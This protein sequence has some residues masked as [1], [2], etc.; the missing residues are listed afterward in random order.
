MTDQPLSFSERRRKLLEERG[1]LPAEPATPTQP[2][3]S[4][5][6]ATGAAW[7]QDLIPDISDD[8]SETDIAI[9]RT[10]ENISILE[11]YQKWIGKEIDWSTRGRADG[12]MVSCPMP[13]HRDSNPSA[14]INE[15]KGVW[16]CGVCVRGGDKFDLAAI[17][18]HFD[19]DDYK[20]GSNFHKV[21]EA[22]AAD[23]GTNIHR[24]AN[25]VEVVWYDE[26]SP[27]AAIA[28]QP[29]AP[30]P[31][32]SSVGAESTG[33]QDAVP[34]STPSAPV[35]PSAP[36]TPSTPPVAAVDTGV[37][38]RVGDADVQP[39]QRVDESSSPV[40]AP[41]VPITKNEVEEETAEVINYPTLDWRSIVPEGT[42]LYEYIKACSVDDSPEEF[43]FWNG[44]MMISLAASRRVYLD[45]LRKTI[46][47]LA[48]VV[49]GPTAVGKT[50]SRRHMQQ[51]LRTVAPFDYKAPT[52]TGIKKVTT[53]GSGEHL[54]KSFIHE[55]EDPSLPKGTPPIQS[56]VTG[57][58][59]FDEYADLLALTKRLGSTLGGQIMQFIDGSDE[60]TSGALNRPDFV[61]RNS[62]CNIITSTQP[63]SI[64]YLIDKN[65]T[66]S[67]FVNRWLFVSGARK[68]RI[69]F[70]G[71]AVNLAR[72]T[73]M[74]RGVVGF[75]GIERAIQVDPSAIKAYIEYFDQV[76]ESTIK[77]DDT[78]LLARMNLHMKKILLL[79]TI[80]NG[81]MTMTLDTLERCKP[82][83]KY[84][85][86]CYGLISAQ[87][88]V[89]VNLEV[90]QDIQRVTEALQKR[91][92]KAP[93][94]RDIMKALA[95][96]KYTPQQMKQTLDNLVALDVIEVVK[97]EAGQVGRPTIRYQVSGGVK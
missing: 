20:S 97:P 7:D 69:S 11:A 18:H 48:I 81:E 5:N 61:V 78:D 90:G 47:N 68:N 13:G 17:G 72:A 76:V 60:I 70:G 39:T 9:D 93:S 45:G 30:T 15:E 34:V 63:L 74:F 55:Y 82:I 88:G 77:T 29:D 56:A 96:K 23:F 49:L 27:L 26:D 3:V 91:H 8:R 79:M 86:H 41:V 71:E 50:A 84:L 92:G 57:Y 89:S 21:R 85:V 2:E 14:W 6:P 36:V 67:G 62:Y 83:F 28:A 66:G 59:E 43:H 40:L 32:E 65:S 73:D 44:M 94:V 4:V 64:K 46:G 80:N 22:M 1:D 38:L 33:G 35:V 95:R 58:A 10:L 24:A 37:V 54:I 75:C 87:I 53:P 12:F 42:F 51:I 52:A 19:L 31:T 16:N 25:N